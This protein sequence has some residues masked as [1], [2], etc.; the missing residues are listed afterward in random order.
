M[1]KVL[2]KIWGTKTNHSRL[3]ESRLLAANFL[4]K[5][6]L[7]HY[8]KKIHC[9]SI[10]CPRHHDVRPRNIKVPQKPERV[11]LLD[12]YTHYYF[13]VV[14]LQIFFLFFMSSYLVIFL[15]RR[16]VFGFTSSV[17]SFALISSRLSSVPGRGLV[18]NTH[19]AKLALSRRPINYKELDIICMPQLT[20][21]V[22]H[23]ASTKSDILYEPR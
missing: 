13:V 21:H 18:I 23:A 15:C 12:S 5:M 16:H 11:I 8:Q 6:M 2:L 9:Y 4:V 7:L 22:I 17:E 20:R 3:R 1:G 10:K 19:T 14:L